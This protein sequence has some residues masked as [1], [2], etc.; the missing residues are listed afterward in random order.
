MVVPKHR[1]QMNVIV[2]DFPA[3]LLLH[4]VKVEQVSYGTGIVQA[5]YRHCPNGSIRRRVMKLLIQSGSREQD[6]KHGTNN[7]VG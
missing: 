4:V 7:K 6:G 2:Y 5:S 3:S 1:F